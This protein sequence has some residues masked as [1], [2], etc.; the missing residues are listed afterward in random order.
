[1]ISLG[2]IAWLFCMLL[3]AQTVGAQTDSPKR[4]VDLLPRDKTPEQLLALVAINLGAEE[5]KSAAYDRAVHYF[6]E[7][8]RLDPG[9]LNA[10][11]Y[12]AAA[13]ASQYVPGAP[14]EENF[15]FGVAAV[16]EFRATLQVAPENLSAIDGLGSI[17][18]RLAG[19]PFDSAKLEESKSLFKK[20]I[21]ISAADPEPYYWV[22]VI[23][24]TSSLKAKQLLLTRF[25][26]H[27]TGEILSE[28]DPLPLDLR[29]QY[30][31]ESGP[32]VDEGIDCMQHAMDLRHDYEDAMTYLNL[33]YRR[34][35]DAAQSPDERTRFLKLADELI[36]KIKEIRAK[37]A[38]S[39]K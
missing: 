18:F 21:Q 33:L 34:K 39:P 30:A 19:A 3:P 2:R 36:D 20:H 1:M 16:Q 4:L 25:N 29:L 12:L 5:F 38:G 24:W 15:K 13:Y 8:R 7:S 11:L 22:G 23:D 32:A 37:R 28:T 26:E 9:L 27:A 31:K 35:A 17:L 14:S 10:R 6:I